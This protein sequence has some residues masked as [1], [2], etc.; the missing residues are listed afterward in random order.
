MTCKQYLVAAALAATAAGSF[1]D[2]G[3][4]PLDLATGS[5]IFGRTDAADSFTDIY[6]FTVASAS[7]ATGTASSSALGAQDLDVASLFI[8]AAATPD[9]PLVS[10]TGNLGNDATEFYS[11]APFHLDPGAYNLVVT[12]ANSLD[13]ASYSG[14]LTVAGAAAVAAAVPEPETYALMLAGLGAVG[15]V[16]AR[17]RAG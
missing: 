8:S 11:L 4:G 12:G 16:A 14:T 13:P 15:F 1:A 5:A 3:G 2:T 17:R 6:T 10:F 7:L 9:V